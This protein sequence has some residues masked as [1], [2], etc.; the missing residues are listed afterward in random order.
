MGYSQNLVTF[1]KAAPPEAGHVVMKSHILTPLARTMLRIGALRVIFTWRDL[2]DAAA[3]AL[4]TFGNTEDTFLD[5]YKSFDAALELLA[6]HR[7]CGQALLLGYEDTMAR[8]EEAIGKIASYLGLPELPGSAI[9][10]L[11]AA[12]SLD[13]SRR[14]VEQINA[15]PKDDL[16]KTGRSWYDASTLF[17][18]NH[19]NDGR[20]GKGREVL[21]PEQW[22]R[23]EALRV[24]HGFRDVMLS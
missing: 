5:F 13:E 11:A 18:R 14:A 12:T 17:H 4:Q 8:P 22:E 24:K 19:I 6:F 20:S 23:L 10:S 1:V 3:S 9:A 16:V 15:R 2:A 21:T 7:A